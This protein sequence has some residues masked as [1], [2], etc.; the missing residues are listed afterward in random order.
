MA[1]R[2]ALF[3]IA[4]TS[5]L[6]A[7][8]AQIF[9]CCRGN[10][11]FFFRETNISSLASSQKTIVHGAEGYCKR[12]CLS[13]K[14]LGLFVLPHPNTPINHQTTGVSRPMHSAPLTQHTRAGLNLVAFCLLLISCWNCLY[15][16]FSLCR[17]ID[18]AAPPTLG[19]Y[20]RS[21]KCGQR[22]SLEQGCRPYQE[23]PGRS[24]DVNLPVR[25]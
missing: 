18:L 21:E 3:F 23:N 20:F 8:A 10:R 4:A 19:R 17:Y 2:D 24:W 7:A 16:N 9:Y 11:L 12:N 1:V 22:S 13:M 14:P 6:L 25:Y 15:G 5:T